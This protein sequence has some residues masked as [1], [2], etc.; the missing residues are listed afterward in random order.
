MEV[1]SMC[2]SSNSND[3]HRNSRRKWCNFHIFYL[4]K[5]L[6]L[7]QFSCFDPTAFRD[8]GSSR[9]HPHCNSLAKRNYVSVEL[10]MSGEASQC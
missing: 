8:S 7:I 9:E 5:S 6:T 1:D 4:A 2:R 10:P 3:T